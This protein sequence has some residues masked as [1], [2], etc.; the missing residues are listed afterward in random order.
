MSTASFRIV[1]RIVLSGINLVD[2]IADAFT[3]LEYRSLTGRSNQT[4]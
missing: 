4:S 2:R 1:S 3:R